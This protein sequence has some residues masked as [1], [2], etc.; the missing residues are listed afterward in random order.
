MLIYKVDLHVISIMNN[1]VTLAL[2]HLLA[3][4][5]HHPFSVFEHL[6]PP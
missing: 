3:A 1:V 5:M 2:S 6:L 4:V